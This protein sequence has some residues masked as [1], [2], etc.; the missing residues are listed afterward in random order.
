MPLGLAE[1][2]QPGLHA[3]ETGRR[4]VLACLAASVEVQPLR[5]ELILLWK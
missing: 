4:P 2:R 5:Q 1:S 3:E